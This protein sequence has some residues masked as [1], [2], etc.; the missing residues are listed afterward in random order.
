MTGVKSTGTAMRR[1]RAEWH[2]IFT[3][4]RELGYT[5]LE[6]ARRHGVGHSFVYAVLNDPTGEGERKRKN[7]YRGTCEDCGAAT[8][9][10]NGPTKAPTVCKDCAA[11]RQ[12]EARHWT[13]E[14]IIAAIQRFARE[15]GRPPT[16]TDWNHARR[17]DGY[18]ATTRVY[19]SQTNQAPLFASWADAI[20]AAGFPRPTTVY[21]RT[22]GTRARLRGHS[23]AG[24]DWTRELIIS[25]I[26][27]WARDHGLPPT[28]IDWSKGT[29]DHPH[30]R[31][32]AKRF[33]SWSAAIAAA[34]FT[35]LAIG[36]QRTRVGA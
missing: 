32:A 7:R 10:S 16:S 5:G 31:T 21:R 19:Q 14:R 24:I 27:D 4:D 25:C 22:E 30:Y 1:N 29:A 34:G 20:V 35:P 11:I 36:Q 13:P 3:A 28:Q 18:P 23:T 15:H 8:D 6:T 26:Q 2:T 33:G 17:Q 9:G 12:H